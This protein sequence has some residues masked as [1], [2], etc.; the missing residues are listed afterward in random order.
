MRGYP[1]LLRRKAPR[2]ERPGGRNGDCEL[3]A[4]S[5]H[6]IADEERML[7]VDV[8]LHARDLRWNW[9]GQI[10]KIEER[11]MV[12]KVF[13]TCVKPPP[14]SNFGDVIDSDIQTAMDLAK[15]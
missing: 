13:L 6:G 4:P 5:Q 7:I 15:D 11:G 14:E 8:I 2:K 3:D 10:L 9:L 12:R 1:R